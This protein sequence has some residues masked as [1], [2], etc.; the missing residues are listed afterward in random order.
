MEDSNQEMHKKN[1][2]ILP[3][4][5]SMQKIQK[6]IGFVHKKSIKW[7]RIISP[8]KPLENITPSSI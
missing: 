2:P 4:T 3:F 1:I 5:T 7:G 8:K 6:L